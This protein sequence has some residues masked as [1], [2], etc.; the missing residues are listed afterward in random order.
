MDRDEL[1][2][3]FA[4]IINRTESEVS[5]AAGGICPTY[6]FVSTQSINTLVL[7]ETFSSETLNQVLQAT[8]K[9][10]GA[11][12]VFYIDMMP[13]ANSCPPHCCC[14]DTHSSSAHR[15]SITFLAKTKAHTLT[16]T[17]LYTD[18][19]GKIEFGPPGPVKDFPGAT[20]L[21]A[22]FDPVSQ[23]ERPISAFN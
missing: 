22:V 9:M 7:C 3:Q 18:E 15:K 8:A 14:A 17:V 20:H 19:E 12:A 16:A 6:Y 10:V 13:S 23:L 4:D 5:K 1:L 21:D 2:K 11:T